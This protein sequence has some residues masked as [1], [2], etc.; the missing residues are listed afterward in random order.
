MFVDSDDFILELLDKE[1]ESLLESANPLPLSPSPSSSL[2]PADHRSE[3]LADSKY[4]RVTVTG[5]LDKSREMFVGTRVTHEKI[6]CL[7]LAW[8]T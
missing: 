6:A 1:Y 5:V 8:T 7:F 4:Q 2:S 3:D